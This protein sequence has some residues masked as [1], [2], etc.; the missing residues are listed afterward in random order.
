MSAVYQHAICSVAATGALDSTKGLFF[1]KDLYAVRPCKVQIP[2][3]Q[4]PTES[5]NIYIIDPE[6]WNYRLQKAPLI[7][8]AWVVQE[9]LLA[10]RV[11]H[12]NRDQLY[13][14]CRERSACEMFPYKMPEFMMRRVSTYGSFKNLVLNTQVHDF[15]NYGT[16]NPWKS[17]EIIWWR[18]LSSY[19]KAQL[20]HPDDK[21]AALSGILKMLEGLFHDT[22][23]AGLWKGGLPSQLVW[24]TKGPAKSSPTYRA[25]SWSWLSIDGEVVP[26]HSVI[27]DKTDRD[28]FLEIDCVEPEAME[29]K[30]AGESA[31]SPIISGFIKLRGLVYSVTWQYALGKSRSVVGMEIDGSKGLQIFNTFDDASFI[32]ERSGWIIQIA[33]RCT[34]GKFFGDGLILRRNVDGTFRRIGAFDSIDKATLYLLSNRHRAMLEGEKDPGEKSSAEDIDGIFDGIFD[35]KLQLQSA[36]ES[37]EEKSIVIV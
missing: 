3:R 14:E 2:A 26:Y 33:A 25:P 10:K 1:K 12:F 11:L 32:V 4:P 8:R 15:F 16:F 21:E 9:R 27:I 20:S 23:I 17:R 36:S 24:T 5:R 34:S 30:R 18:V 28:S 22:Y 6:F 19:S 31:L 7:L 37:I 29:I 35:S 13:W